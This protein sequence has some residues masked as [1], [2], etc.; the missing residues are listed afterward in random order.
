MLEKKMSTIQAGSQEYPVA[1]TLNVLETIQEK[2][3]TLTDFQ[4]QVAGM[5]E[6]EG[7][8]EE[9]TYTAIGIQI[10]PL[11][12]GL[13]LMINEGLR[14]QARKGQEPQ[15][16]TIEKWEAGLIIKE[17]GYSLQ[18]AAELVLE[19]MTQCIAPVKKKKNPENPEKKQNLIFRACSILEKRFCIIRK[20][21]LDR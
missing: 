9:T 16:T 5:V 2:Y 6:N 20:K 1:C 21:K 3:D 7:E 4:Q 19:E 13:T 14:I 17:A 15:K 8:L 11:L 18:A 12:E 10:G